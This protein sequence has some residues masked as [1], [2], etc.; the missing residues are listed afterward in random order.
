MATASIQIEATPSNSKHESMGVTMT[1]DFQ[2]RSQVVT[3]RKLGYTVFE[4][5][6]KLGMTR[7]TELQAISDICQERG[8]RPYGRGCDVSGPVT[9]RSGNYWAA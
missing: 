8:M 7:S 5:G 1:I 3:L 4:I 2:L 6:Q 9:R